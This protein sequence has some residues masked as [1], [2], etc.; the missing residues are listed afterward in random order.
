MIAG[1]PVALPGVGEVMK[2]A[3]QGGRK[4]FSQIGPGEFAGRSRNKFDLKKR[5]GRSIGYFHS[6]S[7]NGK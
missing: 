4:G 1:H 2:K 3:V 6:S 7:S 5:C